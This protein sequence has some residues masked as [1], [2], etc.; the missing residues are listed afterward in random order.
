MYTHFE[1]VLETDPLRIKRYQTPHYK[2]LYCAC[3]LIPTFLAFALVFF[4]VA[5]M[6][7]RGMSMR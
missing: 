1:N 4:L 5:Y 7:P 3:V 2:K 6:S